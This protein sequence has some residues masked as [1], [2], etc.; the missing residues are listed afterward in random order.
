MPPRGI[1]DMP[2]DIGADRKGR[3]HHDDG[4]LDGGVETIVD[5]CCVV[6]G[7]GDTRKQQPEEIGP[8]R[9][10]LVERERGPRGLG[11]DG[12]QAGAGRGFEDEV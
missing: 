4:R 12:E 6:P 7:D 11:M 9:G 10:K 5:M 1:G 2:I 3:V 8:R